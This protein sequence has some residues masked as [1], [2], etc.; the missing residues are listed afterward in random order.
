MSLTIDEL[1]EKIKQVEND[2]VRLNNQGETGRKF[3]VLN[4]YKK[5]LEDELQLIKQDTWFILNK[6]VY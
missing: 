6:N 5:Y 4:E 3:E 1:K 2:I